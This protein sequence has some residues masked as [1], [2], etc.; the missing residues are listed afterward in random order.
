MNAARYRLL[1]PEEVAALPEPERAKYRR[2]REAFDREVAHL[3]AEGKRT[4][5]LDFGDGVRWIL[6]CGRPV[7]GM[8]CLAKRGHEGKCIPGVQR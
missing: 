6:R 3:V 1:S 5:V 7:G 4:G 2:E 8:P